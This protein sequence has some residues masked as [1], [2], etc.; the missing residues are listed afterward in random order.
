MATHDDVRRL[1]L[2]LPEASEADHHGMSSFR[3]NRKIFASLRPA[4][5]KMMVRL[6]P[7]DQRNLSEGHPGVIEP[8]PGYWGRRGSTFVWFDR[9]DEAMVAGLLRL[10]WSGAA[11]KRTRG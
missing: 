10:A 7:E 4:E 8:V 11:P 9:C 6:D 1:A 5:P 3:V 2:A